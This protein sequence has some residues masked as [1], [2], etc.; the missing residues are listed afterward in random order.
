[1]YVCETQYSSSLPKFEHKYLNKLYGNIFAQ[2]W[3][4]E[5]NADKCAEGE[6][7]LFTEQLQSWQHQLQEQC[8]DV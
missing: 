5:I 1:M 4:L 8:T 7:R 3:K 6:G 2:R